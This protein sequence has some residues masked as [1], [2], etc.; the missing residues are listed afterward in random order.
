[1]K[2]LILLLFLALNCFAYDYGIDCETKREKL[3]Y[4]WST[5]RSE[6]AAEDE[7]MKYNA[8]ENKWSYEKPKSQ[9]KYNWSTGEYEY[10]D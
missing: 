6:Y 8:P 2:K 7:T 1:M 10:A 5:N 4:N 3:R 9:L